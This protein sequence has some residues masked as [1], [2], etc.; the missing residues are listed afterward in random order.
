MD[1]DQFMDNWRFKFDEEPPSWVRHMDDPESELEECQSRMQSLMHS[2]RKEEYLQ[3]YLRQQVRAISRR[4]MFSD[5]EKIEEE[6]ESIVSDDTST[7]HVDTST[8]TGSIENLDEDR[9]R[10][11]SAD[12]D[13][14]CSSIV[15]LARVIVESAIAEASKNCSDKYFRDELLNVMSISED[16]S[17]SHPVEEE[18]NESLSFQD[19][20]VKNEGIPEPS[21][22]PESPG[23]TLP[24]L[25]KEPS[26]DTTS[27]DRP[28]SKSSGE[29]A[30]AFK[31]LD[32]MLANVSP[33]VS[34]EPLNSPRQLHSQQQLVAEHHQEAFKRLQQQQQQQG[35]EQ[36]REQQQ[37]KQQ[38]QAEN[39]QRQPEQQLEDKQQQQQEKQQQL[40]Q[41]GSEQQQNPSK[42]NDSVVII[43]E[44]NPDGHPHTH[45]NG[46]TPTVL[47][48]IG[49]GD[50]GPV[51]PSELTNGSHM[52]VLRS[53][54][55]N[56]PRMQSK[57]RANHS[58]TS[59]L[60]SIKRP[61][62]AGVM[63]RGTASRPGSG[64]RSMQMYRVQSG[65]E[66]DDISLSFDDVDEGD[67]DD[68]DL[69]HAVLS[70]L[71]EP[72]SAFYSFLGSSSVHSLDD[73]EDD[74]SVLQFANSTGNLLS[75][76]D[77]VMKEYWEH[78]NQVRRRRKSTQSS[79]TAP[80]D[81]QEVS[82][83]VYVQK[84]CGVLCVLYVYVRAY[85]CVQYVHTVCRYVLF[86]MR[87]LFY[88][89]TL[90]IYELYVRTYIRRYVGSRGESVYVH[91]ETSWSP[92]CP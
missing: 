8:M 45:Q 88:I 59:P 58:S 27:C 30:A 48:E 81:D 3:M 34:P 87:K 90:Y 65:S 44:N 89:F 71:S 56:S 32:D 73:L 14:Q 60:S 41:A 85:I 64:R 77:Y 66:L 19:Q 35:L 10:S 36:Q 31:Q 62:S 9:I 69:E 37:E 40:E 28:D 12:N 80:D 39:Q 16:P 91:T 61:S 24:E 49:N 54:R 92:T 70:N 43:E 51:S 55:R 68:P 46:F 22:E 72:A 79:S 83:F 38:Q 13:S 74:P 82:Q 29:V 33:L 7:E 23:D 25:P 17:D 75:E 53:P 84:P 1:L 6:A 57:K 67:S 86:C 52:S 26:A 5:T 15:E 50:G 42:Q 20:E 63:K 11:P 4:S 47:W 76:G 18:I 21:T 2:L 78:S